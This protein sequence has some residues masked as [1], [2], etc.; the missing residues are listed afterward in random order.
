[1]FGYCPITNG[2]DEFCWNLHKN[3]KL[4][5]DSMYNT[6]IQLNVPVDNKKMLEFKN[7]FKIKVFGWYLRKGVILT[8][9]NL[10]K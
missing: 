8:K 6:L 7:P 10:A 1:M 4:L 3:G 5:V 2:P 9:D